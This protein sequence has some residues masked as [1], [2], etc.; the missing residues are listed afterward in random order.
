MEIDQC[1][2]RMEEVG[3]PEE[4]VTVHPGFADNCLKRWVLRVAGV[5]FKTKKKKSYT[6]MFGQGDVAEHK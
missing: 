6:V 4:C 5:G 1:K 2:T 3:I